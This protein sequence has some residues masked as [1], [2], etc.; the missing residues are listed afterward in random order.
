MIQWT[1]ALTGSEPI[2]NAGYSPFRPT[3]VNAV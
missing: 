1:V 2:E 3:V